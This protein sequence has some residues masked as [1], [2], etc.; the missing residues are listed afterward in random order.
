LYETVREPPKVEP[1]QR[2]KFTVLV[3]A[4]PAG[5]PAFRLTENIVGG[6]TSSGSSARAGDVATN[7]QHDNTT[8]RQDAAP[9]RGAPLHELIG[10]LLRSAMGSPLRCRCRLRP[11]R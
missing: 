4:N 7:I 10:C 1:K 11:V 5:G 3:K 2:G 9:V 6:N 8:E